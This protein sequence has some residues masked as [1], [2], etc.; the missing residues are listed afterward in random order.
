MSQLRPQVF[1]TF[2]LF[3]TFSR[4]RVYNF[5][6]NVHLAR[7]FANG[8]V[9][10]STARLD[11]KVVLVTGANTGIGRETV[12]DLVNRGNNNSNNNIFI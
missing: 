1:L 10:E 3:C 11:G 4:V 8:P 7:W 5:I 6:S 2:M 9:C 12:L